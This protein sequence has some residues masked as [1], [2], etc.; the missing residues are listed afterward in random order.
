MFHRQS[1]SWRGQ[2][3]P[4]DGSLPCFARLARVR[5]ALGKISG[6][7]AHDVPPKPP[8]IFER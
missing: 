2:I 3:Q 5:D 1:G 4:V 8:L 6:D 7:L